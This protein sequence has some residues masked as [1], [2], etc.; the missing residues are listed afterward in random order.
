MTLPR[1]YEDQ[2]TLHVGT[3]PPRAYFIPYASSEGAKADDRAASP[4]FKTLCGTW[5][6]RW[7][8]SVHA[9]PDFLTEAVEY[10]KLPV[11]MNWQNKLGRGY[12]TP[13]YTN[14]DYPIPFDPPYVPDENP[15]GLY[16]RTFTLPEGILGKKDVHLNFEGVDSCFYLY[17]NG[18]FVAYSQVSH[19]TSEI[20][21]T[22]FLHEGENDLKVLVLKWC[23]GTYLEDQ[24]MFRAS[25]IFRE[26]YLLFR[27]RCRIEDVF[28]HADPSADFCEAA[29]SA[30][31]KVSAPATVR[32]AL[33]APDGAAVAS[34]EAKIDGESKVFF[35]NI[36]HPKLWSAEV[37]DL[38]RLELSL[39]EEILSF[40]VGVR[41][42]EIRG[43][44][45]YI[46]GQKAKC[47]GV[48]RHD[49]HPM[50]GHATPY[51]HFLRDV[52]LLKANNVNFVRTSHYPNDPRF[53]TLCDRYGLF[54]CDEADLECHGVAG[55]IYNDHVPL[56]TDPD[57]QE[58]YL[59]RA[60][61]MLARDKNHPAVLIW[62]VGNESGAGINHRAEL[63]LFRRLDPSRLVHAEDE[64]RRVNTIRTEM[65]EGK[66]PEVPDTAYD[67]YDIDSRMY[68][69]VENIRRDYLDDP[70]A[71]KPV[72]LCE[73]AHA[74]G[75]GPG[76]LSDYW[77][78]FYENDCLFG[79]CIWEFTDH[80]VAT[81][82]RVF[83]KPKYVY[84]G[85]FGE[86]PNFSNFCVDGLVY[87]DRRPHTGFK[88]MKQA[89]K[90]FSASLDG[91][92][93]TLT[94]RRYFRDLSDLYAVVRI[95]RNGVLLR[96][97]SLGALTAAPGVPETVRVYDRNERFDGCTTLTV[98]VRQCDATAW[99][100]AGYEVGFAQFVLSDSILPISLPGQNAP[101]LCESEQYY[102]VKTGDTSVSV[103]RHSGLIESIVSDGT[104]MLTAPV[105]PT[106]WR[107]PT[108]N[109]RVI[110]RTWEGDG[111]NLDRLFTK[112]YGVSAFAEE[113]GVSVTAKVALCANVNP[114]VVKMTL[115]YRFDRTGGIKIS[116]D[117][118]VREDLPHL[119]R[120]GF[121]FR[122]P[123][124]AEQV[125]YFGYG[126][127][128]AYEDL[129][130]SSRLSL[131]RTTATENFEH[132]VRPQ[133]NSAHAH[134]RAAEVRSIAGHGLL[135]GADDFSFSVSH[136]SPT[137]L[138]SVRHDYELVPER[139]TTVI[140]D[141]RNSAIGSGSCGPQLPPMHQINEKKIS[142]S[143]GV[144]PTFEAGYDLCS[145]AAFYK[146]M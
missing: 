33:F 38:Y 125:S 63:D 133:E 8:P 37:P 123:E 88:E 51:A 89:Y 65:K 146:N 48:N 11:P 144:K 41:R 40:D 96:S 55:G 110:R 124:G 45:I 119:P 1:Y 128:E 109:D 145:E 143:F 120:F 141:Y 2:H 67:Y 44:V 23:D 121:L 12:D 22:P 30:E 114:P 112:C 36:K 42:V 90:P 130:L 50:L 142:F 93:L 74:M 17:V 98:S 72:W 64:S 66:T 129:L 73:Y 15:C 49:S 9:L 14:V 136:F 28:I 58:A 97:F 99:A 59:D 29:V 105:T 60:Y 106:V 71:D 122:M 91:G 103:S 111:V 80:S 95:E 84:G 126:P 78:L 75:V 94:C 70:R 43:R 107:A 102:I 115:T 87:P 4:Y 25:G 7:Y 19:M 32:Y 52:L 132:Y 79:G 117:A 127:G 35:A 56:T 116:V 137:Y 83:E 62:S 100:E 140:I 82:D 20:D 118:Q 3:L 69:S 92:E 34:G 86:W 77:D 31:V 76:R 13:G 57:W 135:F 134:C 104:E 18:T 113:D 108:D 39:G 139:D 53:L 131:Y 26:V 61:R 6:F 68:P 10:D 138:T 46:N 5:N 85:D 21:I 27:D 24:D 47:R 54:V 16:Q 101:V 81:G